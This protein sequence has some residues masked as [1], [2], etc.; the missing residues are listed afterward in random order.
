MTAAKTR[1]RA[2]GGRAEL[3]GQRLSVSSMS[4]SRRLKYQLRSQ[5]SLGSSFAALDASWS[6][7]IRAFF[8][9]LR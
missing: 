2:G 8:R 4:A 7:D 6:D 1:R 9:A 5:C 3:G